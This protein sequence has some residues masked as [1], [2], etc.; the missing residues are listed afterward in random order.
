M[1]KSAFIV[2]RKQ[3]GPTSYTTVLAVMPSKNGI[4]DF[5]FNPTDIAISKW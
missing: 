2:Y 5:P 1:G 4:L 3:Q